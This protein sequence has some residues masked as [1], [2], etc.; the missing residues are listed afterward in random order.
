MKVMGQ[1]NRLFIHF[2]VENL[3]K[4]IGC[5]LSA[6]R[7]III[8]DIIKLKKCHGFEPEDLKYQLMVEN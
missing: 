8:Y 1:F 6:I 3:I 4:Y 7:G 5:L 2:N